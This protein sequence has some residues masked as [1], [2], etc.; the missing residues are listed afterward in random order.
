VV[1]F[2]DTSVAQGISTTS[3]DRRLGVTGYRTPMPLRDGMMPPPRVNW[4]PMPRP[5]CASCTSNAKALHTITRHVWQ[6]T[7]EFTDAT[8]LQLGEKRAAFSLSIFEA[9]GWQL[10]QR[11]FQRL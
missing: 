9:E 3:S 1:G 5:L 7:R 10:L 8:V 6:D 4:S 11:R 2:N